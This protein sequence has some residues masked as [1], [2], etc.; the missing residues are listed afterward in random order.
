MTELYLFALKDLVMFITPQT[1]PADSEFHIHICHTVSSLT[2]SP[3]YVCCCLLIKPTLSQ[4][5]LDA[6]DNGINLAYNHE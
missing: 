6:L 4:Q 1:T 3:K 2:P 5:S